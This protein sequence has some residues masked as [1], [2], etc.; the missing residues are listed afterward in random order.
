M[1]QSYAFD[2]NV[3]LCCSFCQDW[4]SEGVGMWDCQVR[5]SWNG[6]RG[7]RWEW[8]V[9]GGCGNMIFDIDVVV[10]DFKSQYVRLYRGI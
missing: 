8:M 7:L 9:F 3:D 5:D 1:Y 6:K 4:D 2:A 10:V